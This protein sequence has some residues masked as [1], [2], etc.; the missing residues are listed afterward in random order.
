MQPRSDG[1]R[2]TRAVL[3]LALLPLIIGGCGGSDDSPPFIPPPNPDTTPPVLT[4]NPAEGWFAAN[5]NVDLTAVDDRDPAPVIY[6]TMDLTTPDET[7]PMYTAPIPVAADTVIKCF[8]M[9]ASGNMSAIQ[10]LGYVIASFELKQQWAESGHGMIANEAW[11]HWD[12]DGG[13]QESCARCHSAE[14]FR[15]Y[16]EDGTVDTVA[17]LP[18]GLACNGCHE[19]APNTLYDDL[20]MFPEMEPVVFPSG[21]TA[22]LNGNSNMCMACHQGRASTDSVDQSIEN[23]PAGPYSFINIH[24]YA[25]AATMFGGEVR[26]GYQYEGMEYQ[27]KNVFPSHPESA[28]TCVGCHMQGDDAN[29]TFAPD[30]DSCTACHG[31]TSF[32]TLGGSPSANYA[33]IQTLLVELYAAIQDYADDLGFPIVYDDHA[34]P[35]FFNDLNGNGMGDPDEINYGNRYVQFDAA[36]LKAAYNYQVGEKEPCGYIHNGTYVQQI[37][38]DS[39]MD[40]D[41]SP[42]VIAPGRTGFDVDNASATQQWQLSGHGDRYGEAFRHWDEDGEVPTSC[43]KCHS[44]PGYLDFLEDGTVDEAAALGSTIECLACHESANL[45]ANTRT[46]WDAQDDAGSGPLLDVEFPSGETASLDGPSNMCM[47]CHQGRES[48][49]DVQAVIDDDAGVGPYTFINI[50]YYPAAA[51]M[52]G[53]DVRGGYEYAGEDYDGQNTFPAHPGTYKTCV[54]CHMDSDANHTWEPSLDTCTACHGGTSFETLGFGV[55]QAYDDIQVMLGELLDSIQTYA[56]DVIGVDIG[57]DSHAYPYFFKDLDGDGEI[58]EDEANFGNRY[59]DFDATLLPA[60]YNYQVGQK[61]PC[62]YIHNADYIR[63]LLYDSISDLGDTS[64]VDRP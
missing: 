36:L 14:G 45:F 9:D 22:T 3:A 40:I 63:Q 56:T 46:N 47:A 49:D 38:Y 13:V 64:S 34:Y 2:W 44:T 60:A 61:D 57:Y 37:L 58:G 25:A 19:N 42:S 8:A 17:P 33:A 24:Y 30:V 32:E 27:G 5:V 28:K 29:H 10:T 7:S 23:D 26:G 54:G 52:F 16:A 39:T 6:Y 48:G 53:G 41:G 11:R 51:T 55:G 21:E 12:E 1:R 59:V 31:G 50:H 20:A 35:Y 43:A 4:A 15:D 18:L 62:G